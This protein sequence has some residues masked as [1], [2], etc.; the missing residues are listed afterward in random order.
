MTPIDIQ[1]S[2][3]KVSI[4]GQA[5]SLYVGEGGISILQTAIFTQLLSMTL[6]QGQIAKVTVHI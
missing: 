1:F 4:E 6:T 2:R 5:Y 3:S